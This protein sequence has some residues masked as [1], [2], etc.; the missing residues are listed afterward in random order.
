MKRPDKAEYKCA[1]KG[2]GLEWP[3]I[4]GPKAYDAKTG[5]PRKCPQCGSGY[6]EWANYD[7]W[8]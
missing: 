1:N 6:M 3:D 5:P 8:A 4:P 7:K 2:C